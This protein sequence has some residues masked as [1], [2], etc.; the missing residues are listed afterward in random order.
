MPHGL[1]MIALLLCM[2][3]LTHALV[4]DPSTPSDVVKKAFHCGPQQ[5]IGSYYPYE[6]YQQCNFTNTSDSVHIVNTTL[7]AAS[8]FADKAGGDLSSHIEL[9]FAL[10][11]P[12]TLFAMENATI[13]S[14]GVYVNSQNIT[15]DK[16]SR[17][18]TTA[19][20]LQFGPGFSTT[21]S[22][23]SAYGGMGGASLSHMFTRPSTCSEVDIETAMSAQSIGDL[24]GSLYDFRGFG[25]GGGADSTRGGGSVQLAAALALHLDGIIDAN[26]GFDTDMGSRSGSGVPHP[27]A[28]NRHI[29]IVGGTIVLRA[30]S[31][32]GSGAA[33]VRGGNATKLESDHGGGGGGGGGRVVL[34]YSTSRGSIAVRALGGTHAH[35]EPDLWCQEGGAGTFLEISRQQQSTLDDHVDVREG[36]IW[37][38]GHN[39]ANASEGLMAGTPLFRFTTHRERMIESW[40]LHLRVTGRALLL[41]STVELAD[42]NTS[43][44]L[45][46]GSF[47]ATLNFNDRIQIGATNV[48]LEGCLGPLSN[49]FL[50]QDVVVSGTIVLVS[51]GA[52]VA[53]KSLTVTSGFFDSDGTIR[54]DESIDVD[55]QYDVSLGG[56][57]EIE[58]RQTGRAF[59]AKLR[60]AGSVSM[61][62]DVNSRLLVPL[63]IQASDNARVTLSSLF[64]AVMVRA[65][66]IVVLGHPTAIPIQGMSPIC[67]PW[68]TQPSVCAALFPDGETYALRLL[69]TGSVVL[70]DAVAASSTLICSPAVSVEGTLVADGLGCVDSGR[71]QSDAVHGASGGAGHGGDGGHVMPYKEGAG[72]A[73][74]A[75]TWPQW[76]GSSAASAGAFHGG[77][78]GGLVVVFAST[79]QLAKAGV[80]SVRGGNGTVGGGGGAGG[81]IVLGNVARL[82]GEGVLDISGGAGS[83]PV[84]VGVVHEETTPLGGGGGGGVL[85]VNYAAKGSGKEFS[86]QVLKTG[87]PSQGQAGID[88]V[89][90]GDGCGTFSPKPDSACDPC[91]TG[92][93]SNTSG[94][95]ECTNC[96]KGTF[97]PNPGSQACAACAMGQYAPDDRASSCLLCPQGTFSDH[98]GVA[99]CTLCANGTFAPGNGSTAC[100]LCGIGQYTLAPGSVKCLPCTTK[101]FNSEY[102][103]DGGCAYACHKGRIAIHAK[104]LTPFEAFIEPIGGA[105][106][107]I[108][109]CMLMVCIVFG[110]YSY[111]AYRSAPP[112]SSSST[113][114]ANTKQYHAVR[115]AMPHSDKTHLPRLTDQQ[116]TF[117]V[118]RMHFHGVNSF[119]RPWQLPT[120]LFVDDALRKTI[121]EGSYASF[122]TKCNGLCLAHAKAWRI[123]KWLHHLARVVAPPIAVWL[124]RLYQRATVRHLFK[125]VQEDGTGFFRDL[126]VRASGATL[127]LGYSAD[128][129]LGYFDLLLSPDAQRSLH[130]SPPLLF[131]AAGTGT[132][133]APFHFDSN[134]ALLR[135]VPYRV[136][137]L[138]DSVWLEFVATLNQHLRLVTPHSSL[139]VILDDV[140]AFNAN[141]VLNGYNVEFGVFRNHPIAGKSHVATAESCFEPMSESQSLPPRAKWAIYVVNR[142]TSTRR[143]PLAAAAAVPPPPT[144]SCRN[145]LAKTMSAIR[146]EALYGD[147]STLDD[148]MQACASDLSKTPL[149]PS[150]DDEE[151]TASLRKMTKRRSM[152]HLTSVLEPYRHVPAVATPFA[153]L[154]PYS[155]LFLLS[156]DLFTIIFLLVDFFCI[157]VVSPDPLTPSPGCT[158]VA[159]ELLLLCMPG[160]A[161]GTPLLGVVFVLQRHSFLGRMFVLWNHVSWINVLVAVV[162]F[163]VFH[164]QLDLHVLF[165]L[166]G[167]MVLKQL[168]TQVA[169]YVLAQF[170]A[171]RH[172]R[173]WR[174]LFTT[175]EY[176]DAA[177]RRF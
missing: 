151:V 84:V 139:D 60:S 36:T 82:Q 49:H 68:S 117:H 40:M 21:L 98:K 146:Y 25:S 97:T 150:Q 174:G 4:I 100:K 10:Q 169:L 39:R 140:D 81:T 47:W 152:Q 27:L 58:T 123:A 135:A 2:S 177:Y 93:F 116:L 71:G 22:F 165:L 138:R 59:Y 16:L 155:L 133:L 125:L 170:E 61:Q 3:T 121:Y 90:R 163:V 53:V 105:V 108:L 106:G 43:L 38:E 18:N 145:D 157:Q 54:A 115:T 162:C 12:S 50:P 131:L 129:S 28:T 148:P 17:I 63:E 114:A 24:K 159:F 149:L 89:A 51:K 80:V 44:V 72:H 141:D 166:L 30:I 107:F 161:V 64:R 1:C 9:C 23:G 175:Y 111:V 83:A 66:D 160:A 76:P 173:G 119:A 120:D 101:P 156:V 164:A 142:R 128:Y 6:I 26:G 33:E 41:A 14:S 124:L 13:A 42:A 88:G 130:V 132:F 91:P 55:V 113:T 62:V 127:I 20:G 144:S 92:T 134:D 48:T 143:R 147:S 102:N 85:W 176:Y 103:K 104:C 167:V 75:T 29:H 118:A 46:A 67:Q 5:P 31:I 158:Q 45:E 8:I 96:S 112:S 86:G 154:F 77:R 19:R 7:D 35:L 79:V 56:H 65:A 70:K 110:M 57:V 94:S 52:V 122:A 168:E 171:A 78:G 32:S 95:I 109:L 99:A 153:W 69:A 137:I 73:Y 15:V 37:I 126:D 87:G 34:D 172:G 74:E 136:E 11:G